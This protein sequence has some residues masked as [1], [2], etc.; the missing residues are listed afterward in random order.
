MAVNIHHKG[1]TWSFSPA[2][3]RELRVGAIVWMLLAVAGWA[4]AGAAWTVAVREQQAARRMASAAGLTPVSGPG[5]EVTVSDSA[6]TLAP[7]ENPS[8]ALV[9]DSDLLFLEMMLWYGGAQA[10]AVNGVRI[11]AKTTITSAGPTVVIDGRRLVA[12]FRV[13]AVGDPTLLRNVVMTRGGF[14]DRMREGGLG[15]QVI[16]RPQVTAPA[17]DGGVSVER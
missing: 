6:R 16:L 13:V 11:T 3:I 10:V 5:V 9:Q 1:R 4:A 17:S 2:R 7:G 14:A 15:V 8:E 12:P